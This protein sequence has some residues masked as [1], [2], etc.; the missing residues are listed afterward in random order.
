MRASKKAILVILFLG[1]GLFGYS[2]YIA[3][4]N[5]GVIVT[6]NEFLEKN[7]SVSTYNV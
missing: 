5:I 2:Q 6:E 4:S 1:I 7:D 3:A